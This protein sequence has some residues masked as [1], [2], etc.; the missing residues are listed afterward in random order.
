MAYLGMALG[1]F[2]LGAIFFPPRWHEAIWRGLRWIGRSGW[3]R[4]VRTLLIA[5]LRWLVTPRRPKEGATTRGSDRPWWDKGDQIPG[6]IAKCEATGVPSEGNH[7]MSVAEAIRV[8][9]AE[10]LLT[11]D[12]DCSMALKETPGPKSTNRR[13]RR[14]VNKGGQTS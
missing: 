8:L 1:F 7:E 14:K 2:F 11:I 12:Q 10:G 9:R 6:E 5:F 4:R 13:K 3:L